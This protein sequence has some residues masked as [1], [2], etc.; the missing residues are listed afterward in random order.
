MI[1]LGLGAAD[2]PGYTAQRNCEQPPT[3]TARPT[4]LILVGK[5]LSGC[6]LDFWHAK[7]YSLASLASSAEP[8]IL[9]NLKGESKTELLHQHD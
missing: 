7:N 2:Y 3:G 6:H 5:D 1:G 8:R 4:L 9:K